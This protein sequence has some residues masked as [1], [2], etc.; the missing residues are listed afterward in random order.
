MTTLIWEQREAQVSA[1][2]AS[3]V[4]RLPKEPQEKP[5]KEPGK[6]P[7]MKIGY[8]PDGSQTSSATVEPLV[9]TELLSLSPGPP[10]TEPVVGALVRPGT[11]NG[12]SAGP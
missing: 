2:P 11:T 10:F 6:S 7:G 5:R 3:Q 9:C 12:L 8:K 1:T 4:Q